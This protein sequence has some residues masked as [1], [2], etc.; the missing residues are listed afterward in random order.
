MLWMKIGALRR[1]CC[2]AL[3][4][5]LY[6]VWLFIAPGLYSH[7]KRFAIPFVL[8]ASLFFFGGAAFSHYIAFPF[9]WGFFIEL[10]AV[11]SCSSCRRSSRRSPST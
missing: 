6:Q 9:T 8:F 5:V 11:G 4:F 3:P 7:E 1:A 10:Q 2:I